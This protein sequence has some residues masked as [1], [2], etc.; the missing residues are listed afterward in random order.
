MSPDP[1]PHSPETTVLIIALTYHVPP[2]ANENSCM[3]P[4]TYCTNTIQQALE[5][6][7][8]FIKSYQLFSD[9]LRLTARALLAN[10]QGGSVL[11]QMFVSPQQPLQYRTILGV[12]VH[13]AAVFFGRQKVDILLPFVNML[14]NPALLKVC[15][16]LFYVYEKLTTSLVALPQR[17]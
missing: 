12:V 11:E 14:N 4:C 7:N 16:K 9:E 8:E 3:K 2:I 10:Q 13:A 6:L 15:S 5:R 1:P 17:M